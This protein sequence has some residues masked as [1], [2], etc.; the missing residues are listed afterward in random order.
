[1]NLIIK[2]ISTDLVALPDF[3]AGAMEHWGVV[4]FRETALLFSN[5]TN[6]LSNM[7]S[8]ASIVAHELAHFVS[9]QKTH[10]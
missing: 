7:Q 5:R 3:P 9:L 8:V 6:A 10:E 4:A 1:M 2:M